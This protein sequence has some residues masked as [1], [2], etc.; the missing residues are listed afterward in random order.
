[1]AKTDAKKLAK[2]MLDWS[3][4]LELLGKIDILVGFPKEE[5]EKTR[6]PSPDGTSTPLSNAEIAALQEFGSDTIPARPFLRPTFDAPD[7]QRQV[8]KAL[9]VAAKQIMDG[10]RVED[11]AKLV[12][13]VAQGMVRKF[14]KSVTDPPN[15]P[16]TIRLKQSSKPLTDT[17][18]LAQAVTFV[19]R[20]KR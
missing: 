14:M 4:G 15:S 11:G 20:K 1:M 3:K 6:R 2:E 16:Q 9:A 5:A 19:I 18:Q 10:K 17:G 8:N 12:G 7:G 13:V